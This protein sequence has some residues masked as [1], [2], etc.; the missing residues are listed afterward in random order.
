LVSQP[1]G[2]HLLRGFG[3]NKMLKKT[4]GPKEEE[5]PGGQKKLLM[6]TFII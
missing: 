4:F 1:N 6:K 2:E 3:N 5:I